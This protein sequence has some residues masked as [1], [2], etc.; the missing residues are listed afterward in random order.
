MVTKRILF[1]GDSYTAGA[2]LTHVDSRYSKSELV[3]IKNV[4]LDQSGIR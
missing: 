3:K 4:N 2:E 1:A